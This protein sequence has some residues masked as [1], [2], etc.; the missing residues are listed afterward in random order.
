MECITKAYEV[1]STRITFNEFMPKWD[2]RETYVPN[3]EWHIRGLNG[4]KLILQL[5]G[6]GDKV[7]L[8]MK[9]HRDNKSPL[10]IEKFCVSCK[11]KEK[12]FGSGVFMPHWAGPI[13]SFRKLSKK[14][15]HKWGWSAWASSQELDKLVDD[16]G[17]LTIM[18]S[19]RIIVSPS[20][21]L[22]DPPTCLKLQP[23]DMVKALADNEVITITGE[24]DCEVKVS[25]GLL[26]VHSPVIAAALQAGFEETNT[27][28][29]RMTD[30]AQQSIED[31]HHC[32]VSGGLPATIVTDYQRLV[33]LL[34]LADKYSIAPLMDACTFYLSMS[35]TPLNAAQLLMASDQHGLSR[36]RRAVMYFAIH[37][38]Q[39]FDAVKESDEYESFSAEILREL[40]AYEPVRKK[41][42]GSDFCMPLNG[43]WGDAP[44]E[45]P[46]STD[47]K[48]LDKDG[49][50]RACFERFLGTAGTK[51]DLVT[52]LSKENEIF[53]E[54][55]AKRQRTEYWLEPYE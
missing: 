49:L 54:P 47:W 28:M 6:A 2:A 25:A 21:D 30:V 42:D 5:M 4:W 35:I 50:R 32:L 48:A 17:A 23:H 8:W 31:L 38:Y 12:K 34:I 36:L 55:D 1:L 41:S 53:E 27:R 40:A 39:G 3:W 33:K 46:D 24:A 7:S 26:K 29:I 16:R 51:A 22:L 20:L 19:F 45:F 43:Q 18:I 37:C 52:R 14:I 15:G 9:N 11:D 13:D 44:H 10:S